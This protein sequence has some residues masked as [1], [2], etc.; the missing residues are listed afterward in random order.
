MA[1][2]K[3]EATPLTAEQIQQ[4]ASVF[5]PSNA[6]VAAR[7]TFVLDT[8]ESNGCTAKDVFGDVKAHYELQG[9]R[10]PRGFSLSSVTN[11]ATTGRLWIMSGTGRT[12]VKQ[13]N[14][15]RTYADMIGKIDTARN[16]HDKKTVQALIAET[17]DSLQ[18]DVK[19]TVRYRALWDALTA[20][21]DRAPETKPDNVRVPDFATFV[22]RVQ[23]LR[24]YANEIPEDAW[25]AA[26][27][28]MDDDTRAI[29]EAGE[30]LLFN[31]QGK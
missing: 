27:A 3:V 22:K 17:L 21:I 14:E 10:L 2:N 28:N 30:A 31:A 25:Q 26:I 12:S 24:D 11:A 16:A 15:T 9:K 6:D 13:D 23:A 7:V 4:A 5:E 29:L 20:L 1:T 19:P 18:T 8:M